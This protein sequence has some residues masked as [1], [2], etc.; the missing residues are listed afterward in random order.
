MKLRYIF[1]VLAVSSLVFASCEDEQAPNTANKGKEKPTVQMEVVDDS[2]VEFTLKLTPSDDAA[3]YSY[4]VFTADSYDYNSIPSAYDL[5]TNS[6]ASTFQKGSFIK[7]DETEKEVNV[8]CVLKDYYQVC[9]AAISK[10]GLL[11]EVDTMT[12]HIPGAHPDV[13]FVDGIYTITPYTYEEI[14]EDAYD[15]SIIDDPFDI[16]IEEVEPSVYVASATWFG[17]FNFQFTGAY[18]FSANTLTFDGCIY[19][20][21][22][23]GTYMGYIVSSLGSG[24]FGAFFGGGPNGDEPLVLQCEVVDKKAT[25]TSIKSGAFEFDIYYNGGSGYSWFGIW[26]VFDED[27][28]I[29]LKEAFPEE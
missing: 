26:G 18:D 7:G 27:C 29:E 2:D 1:T 5:V 17:L 24:F 22:A 14:G 3:T 16:T 6:V 21:E 9:V 23:E 8:K 25:V 11:S 13:D 4:V 12:V 15:E 19:G 10:D 20:R 28:T